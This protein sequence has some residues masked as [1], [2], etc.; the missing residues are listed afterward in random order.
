MNVCVHVLVLV[1]KVLAGVEVHVCELVTVDA[2]LFLLLG[3][4]RH[5][6]G[7]QEDRGQ[8]VVRAV[9]GGILRG[10]R[11]GLRRKKEMQDTVQPRFMALGF[12]VHPERT[13]SISER[14]TVYG[15]RGGGELMSF[16]DINT[17]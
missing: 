1:V 13:S 3:R 12:Q 6:G 15:L 16:H 5:R 7:A 8:H 9:P 17:H 4:G 2:E 10:I 14:A 11:H